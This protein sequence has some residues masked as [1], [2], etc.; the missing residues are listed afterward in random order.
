MTK[1]KGRDPIAPFTYFPERKSGT[2]NSN[3]F[4]II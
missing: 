4:L 3:L 1:T 2:P